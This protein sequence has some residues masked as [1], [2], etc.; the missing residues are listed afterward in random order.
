MQPGDLG[1][2]RAVRGDIGCYVFTYKMPSDLGG[3]SCA[4]F[5]MVLARGIV[6]APAREMRAARAL[7]S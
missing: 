3:D 1:S 5:S 7:L 4:R 2:Y 6:L